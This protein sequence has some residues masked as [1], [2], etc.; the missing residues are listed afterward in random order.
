MALKRL[1]SPGEGDVWKPEAET[2]TPAPKTR[3]GGVSVSLPERPSEPVSDF[4][5]YTTL[6]YGPQ[7]IGK[8]SLAARFPEALVLMFEPGGKGLRLYKSEVADWKEFR[9]YI[10]ILIKDD[11]FQTVVI[12]TVDVAFNYCRQFVCARLGVEHP[13]DAGYGKG[14][15]A[16]SQEWETQLDRLFKSGKGVVFVSHE[17][18]I[19]IEDASGRTWLRI[20]PTIPERGLAYLKRVCDIVGHYGYNDANERVF[21]IRGTKLLEAKCRP[22]ENF[23]TP[24]EEPVVTIPMGMNADEAY[25]NLLAAFWNKQERAGEEDGDPVRPPQRKKLGR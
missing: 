17:K 13:T 21:R 5:K 15:D 11:R 14:W 8:T 16:L 10:D 23:I 3:M 19:E 25:A 12:D 18:Q 22:E 20:Q 1:K 9:A 6:I 24:A 2:L 7:G 4:L